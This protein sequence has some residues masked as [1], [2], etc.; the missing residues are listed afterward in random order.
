M[1]SV[2]QCSLGKRGRRTWCTILRV[3]GDDNSIRRDVGVYLGSVIQIL[4]E[5]V[6]GGKKEVPTVDA[7]VWLGK[8][9]GE[10]R[11]ELEHTQG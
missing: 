11:G 8:G 7:R 9:G 5:K 6:V 4:K 1:Q 3:E 2:L 10:K